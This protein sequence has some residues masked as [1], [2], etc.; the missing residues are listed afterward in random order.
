MSPVRAE[1]ATA[2]RGARRF[3]ALAWCELKHPEGMGGVELREAA[4]LFWPVAGSAVDSGDVMR[5][6][7]SC[8]VCARLDC[9]AR[10]EPSIM[11]AAG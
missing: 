6:G 3:R 2:G 5:V 8:R 1:M 9:P 4:M 11:A 10:R 7:S